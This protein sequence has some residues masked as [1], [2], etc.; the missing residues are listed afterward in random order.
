[1]ISSRYS[2][3]G[4]GTQ[5]GFPLFVKLAH[6][7]IMRAPHC[8]GKLNLVFVDNVAKDIIKGES[9]FVRPVKLDSK[10]RPFHPIYMS[11]GTSDLKLNQ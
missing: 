4:F 2:I 5:A 10:G 8:E 11:T 7:P 3:H 9:E 1:M 6:H